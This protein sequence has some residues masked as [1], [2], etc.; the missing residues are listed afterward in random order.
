MTPYLRYDKCNK[1]DMSLVMDFFGDEAKNFI[2]KGENL[3][4]SNNLQGFRL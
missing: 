1:T 3:L 2:G 4:A